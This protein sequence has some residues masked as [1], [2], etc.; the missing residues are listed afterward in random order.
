MNPSIFIWI[1][2]AL[3]IILIA[4]LVVSAKG[5]KQDTEG[6]LLQSFGLLFAIIAAFLLPYLPIF[7]FVNF[8]PVNPV[9]SSIGVIV[10]I[11]GMVFFVSARQHL[12]RNWSQ[13]VSA[14]KGHELVTSGPYQYVRHPMYTGGVIACI[15][16]AIVG[17]GAWIFLLVILGAI[18]IWR[19]GAEDKLMEQQFP[20]EFP[21]YKKRTK[22]LIPF[23]W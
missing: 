9:V 18:F 14:K 19:V 5:A 6:H 16:S 17:G 8:A 23:V 1:I 13:T 22:A 7:S 12:G 11:V 4:Y 21:D 3:W 10:Y 2:Y 20:N 15:G